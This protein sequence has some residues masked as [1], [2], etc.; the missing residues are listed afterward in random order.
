MT[1]HAPL[2]K[3][4]PF[5]PEEPTAFG[6]LTIVPLFPDAEPQVDY[7]GLDEASTPLPPRSGFVRQ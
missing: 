2:T 3:A 1:T 6:G 4:L 5:Q 7:I